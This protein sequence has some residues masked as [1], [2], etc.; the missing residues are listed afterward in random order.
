M[1]D[2][3]ERRPSPGTPDAAEE[4]APAKR[5]LIVDD[6]QTVL[7]SLSDFLQFHGFAVRAAPGASQGMQALAENDFDLVICDL[8]MPG[9]DG[10]ALIKLIR[11]SGKEVPLLVMTGF[12]SIE[13]AVESMK[14]GAADFI[15]KPLKLDHVMLIV[16]RVLETRSLRKMAQEREYYKDLSNSD[17]LT[18]ISNFRHFNH[19]LRV[20]IDRQRRYHRPLTLLMIDIDD[21]KKTNDRHGHL[22]GDMV[23]IKIAGLLKSQIRGCDFVARYGGDEFTI[24]LPEVSQKEALAVGRRI[25][26]AIELHKFQSPDY[27]DIG[28]ISVT[29]GIASFPQDAPDAKELVA[30]ADRAMY[31][32]KSAGKN[33]ICL[34]GDEQNVIRPQH[35]ERGEGGAAGSSV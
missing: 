27:K 6:D 26:K 29:I 13:Y 11:E 30:R 33:C 23:L 31:A 32:G 7:E 18:Q 28:S 5:I 20:E 10:I 4:T 12:A 3:Q 22:I 14:A 1:A 17:G 8:V 21:F 19:L 25:Q 24:I 2:E 35:R 16:N 34:F 9:M 15:T